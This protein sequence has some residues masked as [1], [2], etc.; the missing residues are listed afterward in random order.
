V[1]GSVSGFSSPQ[2][3]P[4]GQSAAPIALTLR[5]GAPAWVASTGFDTKEQSSEILLKIPFSWLVRAGLASNRGMIMVG[6]LIGLYFQFGGDG[7]DLNFAWVSDQ[8]PAEMSNA[9]IAIVAT[10]GS[11]VALAFFRLLGVG[12]YVLRFFGYKLVRRGEDLRIS[13]GLF[14]KVSAT[15]PRKRVQFVSIQRNLILRWLGFASIRIETAG[16]ATNSQ[17]DATEAVSKR[18]FI[19][20]IPTAKIP[21]ILTV[22]RPGLEWDESRLN[23]RPMAVG[24]DWRLCRLAF[25]HSILI[26]VGGFALWQPW[27]WLAGVVA[28][29]T[30]L[31]WAFKKAKAMKYAR[32]ENS[33]IYRSGVFTKKTS[34]TF[35]EKVQAL[36]V[37]QSPFDRK[38]K[39]AR[40]HVDTAAAGQ[41][42]HLISVPY[43]DAQFAHDEFQILRNKTGQEHPVFG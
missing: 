36:S 16:G 31:V 27:G 34:M 35:Y 5:P 8:L 43:L 13:C 10:I 18:W 37:D 42:E 25:L 38:W 7:S 14:T 24:T 20:V 41:A 29:P 23:Y 40:L 9:W 12:W 17:Q 21:E 26:A 33:V 32:T 3:D 1:A 2:V 6:V 11:V 39:M 19:P 30:L 28:L 22:L 15:I 4:V